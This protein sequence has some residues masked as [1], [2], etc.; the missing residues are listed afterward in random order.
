MLFQLLYERCQKKLNAK[1]LFHNLVQIQ[2]YNF[3][4]YDKC[5]S[6]DSN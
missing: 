2:L 4:Q 6:S 3:Q 5:V 1:Y